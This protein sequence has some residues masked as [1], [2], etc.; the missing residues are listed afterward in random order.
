[1][2]ILKEFSDLFSVKEFTPAAAAIL[3]RTNAQSRALEEA[4]LQ[5]AIPYEI[6]GG[7]TFYERKE[8]KDIVAYLRFVNNPQDEMAFRRMANVPTRGVGDKTIED[9][10]KE[11]RFIS[12]DPLDEKV[13]QKIPASRRQKLDSLADTIT[14]LRQQKEKI[15]P[16]T[17]LKEILKKTDFRNW[18]RQEALR[19]QGTPDPGEARYENVLELATVAKRHQTLTSLL[20]E[21]ALISDAEKSSSKS[22]EK[23]KVKLMTIH[24]AK[25]LEFPLVAVAGLEEGLLPHQNSMDSAAETEEE[26]R[27]CYVAITRAKEKL[28]LSYARSRTIYGKMAETTPSRFIDDI[29][30]HTGSAKDTLA[31]EGKTGTTFF[32]EEPVVY[33]EEDELPYKAGE[34]VLHETFGEGIV[35]AVNGTILSVSFAEGR[36]ELDGTIAP[37]KKVSYAET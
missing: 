36:K 33:V 9:C 16:G 24:A 32:E 17:I 28:Y 34:K 31:G 8:V 29:P 26:R 37:L 2:R 20:E 27:L 35:E 19:T 4:C 11:A 6:I 25:G 3:Y 18:L 21:I 10:L 23:E 30:D 13:R 7:L 1:M 12:K 15:L 5:L 14:E 22:K